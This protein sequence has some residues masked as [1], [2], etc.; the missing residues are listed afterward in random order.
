LNLF[1]AFEHSSPAFSQDVFF[2]L[3]VTFTGDGNNRVP[4]RAPLTSNLTRSGADVTVHRTAEYVAGGL[5][6]AGA[7]AQKKKAGGNLQEP[8]VPSPVIRRAGPRRRRFAG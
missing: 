8:D 5:R 6:T 4:S 1:S 2:S 7:C 3:T